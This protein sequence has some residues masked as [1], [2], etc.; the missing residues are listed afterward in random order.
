MRFMQH[1]A[2]GGEVVDVVDVAPR[3]APPERKNLVRPAAS[4]VIETCGQSISHSRQLGQESISVRDDVMADPVARPYGHD[5]VLA[6]QTTKS[7]NRIGQRPSSRCGL[8]DGPALVEE[9][10]DPRATLTA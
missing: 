10:V 4:D 5:G 2:I 6:E 1:E 9:F 7:K 3:L 8:F